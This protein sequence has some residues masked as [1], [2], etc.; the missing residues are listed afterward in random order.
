MKKILFMIGSLREE[1]FNRK[2]AATAERMIA[3]RAAVEYL[4]YVDL[5]LMD[6]DI[7]LS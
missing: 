2:L 7:E 4:S 1:S 3:G 5:P 6:Q